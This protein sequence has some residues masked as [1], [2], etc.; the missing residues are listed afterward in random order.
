M[1]IEQLLCD[2]TKNIEQNYFQLPIDGREDPV[3]RERVYCY[4]LYHQM[5]CLWPAVSKYE[6]SGE[7]DKSGHP[8]I[9]GNNLDRVKPDLLVH[10]PGD[11]RG[12]H[13]I[14]EVKPINASQH[15]V[16]KDLETLTA[17]RRHA[18]YGNAIYLIYGGGDI[19][20]IINVIRSL[21]SQ[22]RENKIDLTLIS[23]WWHERVGQPAKRVDL[24]A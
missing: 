14:I 21:K 22:D 3:Y 16:E 1:N 6:L 24:N 11:M 5:R 23:L 12:N 18:H 10:K 15:G 4:E 17:F 13:T 2:A 19:Q 8:L 20:T 9:R 7:V